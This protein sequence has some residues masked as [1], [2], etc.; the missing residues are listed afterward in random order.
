MKDS[1][2]PTSGEVKSV[3]CECCKLT[4]ECTEEYVARVRERYQGIWICGLCREA[5]KDEL[6]RSEYRITTMEALNRHSSFC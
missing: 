6:G 4:E 1:A 3:K 5:V 2:A